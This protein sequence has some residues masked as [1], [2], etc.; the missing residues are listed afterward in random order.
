MATGSPPPDPVSYIMDA[1]YSFN[2]QATDFIY[3]SVNEISA[4]DQVQNV[5]EWL[6]TSKEAIVREVE[7]LPP[8]TKERALAILFP[9]EKVAALIVSQPPPPSTTERIFNWINQNKLL[10]GA[11]LLGVTGTTYLGFKYRR[12]YLHLKK[13]RR[14]ARKAVNGARIEAVVL[15][16]SPREPIAK[17][18]AADL[19]RRG[20][21][22]FI[23][24]QP[25]EEHLVLK[26]DSPDIRPLI[27]P[28]PDS[29]ERNAV[30]E[31]F[32]GLVDRH[33]HLAGVI[34]LPD[35]Y[36]PTGPVESINAYD[37]S[38][39]LYSKVV[40]SVALLSQGFIP[41][42]R[43]HDARFIL[44][45]PSILPSLCLPF[46]APEC[47]TANALSAFALCM[48]RELAPQGIPFIHMRLGS[49]DMSVPIPSSYSSSPPSPFMAPSTGSVHGTQS[50]NRY[51]RSYSPATSP[52]R[53]SNT[54]RADVLSWPENIRNIYGKAYSTA[55][56]AISGTASSI[57]SSA[58]SKRGAGS[59][60]KELNLAIVD[61]LTMED[62]KS[63]ARTQFVGRGSYLFFVLGGFL[64]ERTL[65]WFLGISQAGTSDLFRTVSPD[66]Y[67]ES[68]DES[69]RPQDTPD[70]PLSSGVSGS[71]YI[72]ETDSGHPDLTSSWER[73]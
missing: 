69:A 59:S 34:I 49:F 10:A 62:P 72:S 53:S 51:A 35:L 23:T 7:A 48:Q 55:S 13:R 36:Y 45:T 47:V 71:P 14:R 70:S 22:V 24:V 52:C 39:V 18:I 60:L 1:V 20:F 28:S 26:E 21:I 33:E 32:A 38:D 27:M 65:E 19:E 68:L 17:I 40:G 41:L 58:S 63:I 66:A 64:P 8:L 15:A 67:R 4:N 16:S 43:R 57:V 73:V 11:L 44:L 2:I 3:K 9:A 25:G 54:I 29:I 31:K 56:K 42:V 61:C 5:V 6:T 46:H 30:V 50:P 37:W 12:Q